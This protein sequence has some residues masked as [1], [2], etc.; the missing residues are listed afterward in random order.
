[1]L[2][3]LLASMEFGAKRGDG[4]TGS[5]GFPLLQ[6]GRLSARLAESSRHERRDSLPSQPDVARPHHL[7]D[8]RRGRC[9][10][11]QRAS[12]PRKGRAQDSAVSR[13]QSGGKIPTIVHHVVIISEV[14][15]IC[16][17]LADAFP[18]AKLSPSIDGRRAERTYAGCASRQAASSPR[19]SITCSNAPGS[20]VPASSVTAATRTR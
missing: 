5:A 1:M 16:A 15:A 10:V 17:Y 18:A 9:S 14:A 7:L 20:M 6:S 13:L 8:A 4:S 11:P 3:I 2:S 19:S 12:R